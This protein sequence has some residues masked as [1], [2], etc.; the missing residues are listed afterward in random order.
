MGKGNIASDRSTLFLR[1]NR[2]KKFNIRKR[3]KPGPFTAGLSKAI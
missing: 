3:K 1:S 2:F